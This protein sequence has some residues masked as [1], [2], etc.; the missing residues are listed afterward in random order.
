[1]SKPKQCYGCKKFALIEV[2]EDG[3]YFK[4]CSNCGKKVW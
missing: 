4:V 2:C 1:M 3:K